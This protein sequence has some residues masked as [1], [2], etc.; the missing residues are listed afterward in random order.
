MSTAYQKG[1][2]EVVKHKGSGE[3]RTCPGKKLIALNRMLHVWG[4]W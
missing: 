3:T 2:L 4:I 1:R